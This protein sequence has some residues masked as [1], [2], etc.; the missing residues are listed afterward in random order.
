MTRSRL[1]LRNQQKASAVT[2]SN[3][4]VNEAGG[5]ETGKTATPDPNVQKLVQLAVEDLSKELQTGTDGIQVSSIQAVV[6]P[7]PSL[8]CPKLGILYA[9]VVTPGYIIVLEA[10]GK[11]YSYHTDGS[12]T[13]ILCPDGGLPELIVTPGEILDGKPWMPVP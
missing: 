3:E 2:P 8:G 12:I 6:W 1:W 5:P 9:Q 13:V 11:E 7:D 4:P 10:A